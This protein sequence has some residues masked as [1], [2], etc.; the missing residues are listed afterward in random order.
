LRSACPEKIV[1]RNAN[2][3]YER[4]LIAAIAIYVI[5]MMMI[6]PFARGESNVWLKAVYALAPVPP[7]IYVIWLMAQRIM[8]SDEL[9]QRTHMIGLGVSAAV[10]SVI[11][12]VS[13]FLAA[14]NVLTLDATATI[15]LWI[16]PLLMFT[17]GGVRTY[18]ARR[19]GSNGCDEDEAMPLYIRFL[20]LA[21][22]FCAVGAYVYFHAHDERASSFALGMASA[23]V[24]GAI[25]F[26]VRRWRKRRTVE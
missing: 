4:R 20:V 10:V 7:M 18:A 11:S 21:A 25:Y 24:V 26:G 3:S 23:L 1:V 6:W 9:E 5:I 15:L 8:R 17:Y 16:F 2:R 22:L 14:A 19:Y 13:G 12:L